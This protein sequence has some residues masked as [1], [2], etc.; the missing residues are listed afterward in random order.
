MYIYA[1]ESFLTAKKEE[2]LNEITGLHLYEPSSEE[3]IKE[4]LTSCPNINRID[5]VSPDN[6]SLKIPNEIYQLK[7]LDDLK[8]R[9]FKQENIPSLEK[10]PMLE[11]ID[12]HT[13]DDY[14]IPNLSLFTKLREFVVYSNQTI[15]QV[16]NV[17]S[18][19]L[20]H[21][22]ITGNINNDEIKVVEK[23]P[24]LISLEIESEITELPSLNNSS[25]LGRLNISSKELKTIGDLSKCTNLKNINLNTPKLQ[26][27]PDL[28]NGHKLEHINL[29]SDNADFPIE[30]FSLKNTSYRSVYLSNFTLKDEFVGDFNM[31]SLT[32]SNIKGLKQF[33]D[34]S[35][36][37]IYSLT[38]DNLPD[39]EDLGTGQFEK[40]ESLNS[41]HLNNI[42]FETIPNINKKPRLSY[43]SYKH[44]TTTFEQVFEILMRLK[45]KQ[46]LANALEV[47]YKREAKVQSFVS[48]LSQA[49]LDLSIKKQF[50]DHFF[51]IFAHDSK[52]KTELSKTDILRLGTVN[53]NN[54]QKIVNELIFQETEKSAQ[55]AP[56]S[57]DMKIAIVGNTGTKKTEIKTRLKEAGIEFHTKVKA[58]TTHV[59]MG[60]RCKDFTLSEDL[61][62][63]S[64]QTLIQYLNEQST[65]YLL[66]EEK[67]VDND[68]IENIQSL[69]LSGEDNALVGLEIL[70]AGGVPKELLLPL[71]LVQKTD[72][73]KKVKDKARKLLIANGGLDYEK[74]LADRGRFTLTK[75]EKDLSKHLKALDKKAP[76]I[77]WL[78]FAQLYRKK[79]NKGARFIFDFAKKDHPV[80]KDLFQELSQGN[81]L[82]MFAAIVQSTPDFLNYYSMDSLYEEKVPEEVF[83]STELTQ[84]SLKGFRL[85]AL[86]QDL[87]NLKK[88][89]RLD[90]SF[91]R[92]KKLPED[93]SYLES[94]EYLNLAENEFSEFPMELTQ[95]K[96]L[97]EV[98]FKDNRSYQDYYYDRSIVEI[99]EEAKKALPNCSFITE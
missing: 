9:Y 75:S 64:E 29:S 62:W 87:Q 40:C 77:N 37:R 44:E 82:D 96:N 85:T 3:Q 67:S 39:L 30:V 61:H 58:D 11:G 97:K 41:L 73:N 54:V 42:P 13:L 92:L 89:R 4:I 17:E 70:G 72:T 7:K 45:P 78:E 34:I 6:G 99:P 79:T 51:P 80:R 91:N 19:V 22:K 5:L 12:I 25:N 93:L 14:T 50:F 94:V 76:N 60:K 8:L 65:P 63:V 23:L 10:I 1:Y 88:L 27:I 31:Y 56:I 26:E 86:P 24:N 90:F 38:L 35:D 66:E 53:N 83:E 52:K 43:L 84:L 68:N 49:K 71:L 32:L 69:L 47:A 28:S 16:S 57:S 98:S 15:H 48:A 21:L 20:K 18:G 95:L 46:F 33:P 36:S 81:E 74:A 2:K 55:E 59:V